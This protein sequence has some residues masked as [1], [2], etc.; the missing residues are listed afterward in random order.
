LIRT[1]HTLDNLLSLRLW[2]AALL[3]H[4]LRKD[5]VDLARHVRG[6]TADVEIGFLQ[7]QLVDFF[8]V[9]LE[10]VLHVDF[11]WAFAGE[12]CDEGEFIAQGFFV[13]LFLL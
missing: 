12:G 4:D 3:G 7:E 11:L 9:L 6:I 8:G 5:G 1:P 2:N 13:G 10:P